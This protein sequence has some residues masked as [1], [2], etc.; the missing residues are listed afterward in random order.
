MINMK[1]QVLSS[2]VVF[3]I[4]PGFVCIITSYARIGSTIS[5]ATH[6]PVTINI[7]GCDTV[8]NTLTMGIYNNGGEGSYIYIES[9]ILCKTMHVLS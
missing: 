8:S 3:N 5:A 7:T 6:H 2:M 9:L 1:W 4:D